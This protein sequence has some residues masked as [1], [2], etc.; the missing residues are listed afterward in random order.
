M[1][2]STSCQAEASPID[3]TDARGRKHSTTRGKL[4]FHLETLWLFSRSDL[5]SMVYPNVVLGFSSAMAGPAVTTNENPNFLDVL[6]NLPYVA[7]WLWLNLLLFNIANQRLPSSIVEDRI[8]KPW[9]PIP[10][11]RISAAQARSL[12]LLLIPTVLVCSLYLGATLEVLLLVSLTWMYNDLGGGDDDFL[13]RNIINAFGMSI[14]GSGAIVIACGRKREL[15]PTGYWWMVLIGMVIMTTLQVQDLSDQE[16]DSMRGR[17]TLPLALGEDFTRWT[18]VISVSGWSVAGPA[19][20][21]AG[22]E[23]SLPSLLIGAFLISK[24]LVSRSVNADKG[25]WRIWCVWMVSLYLMPL[26]YRL[27]LT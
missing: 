7:L 5:K 4:A 8:N 3:E 16:G 23:T 13:V 12:L 17:K 24:M 9:R 10:S 2:T 25:A 27:S 19:F 1:P 22:I 11:G 26:W 21:N 14:Y 15:T 18:V 20:W 6:I